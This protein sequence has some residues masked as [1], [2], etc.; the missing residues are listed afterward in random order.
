MD[1]SFSGGGMKGISYLGVLKFFQEHHMT[2][3]I[4]NVSGTSAG[5]LFSLCVVLGYTYEELKTLVDNFN[6]SLIEDFDVNNFFTDYCLD[7]GQ[8]L[9]YF[10]KKILTTKGFASNETFL[11]LYLKTNREL[12]L[13]ATDLDYCRTKIYNYKD[14]PDELVYIA[15]KYSMNIPFLWSK[16]WEKL[17]GCLTI[18]LPIGVFSF[19]N[20]YG[21]SCLSDDNFHPVEDIKD[22]IMKIIKC[23]SIR[24][25]YYEKEYYRSSG[26]KIIDIKLNQIDSLDFDMNRENKQ[27]MI[28][29]GYNATTRYFTV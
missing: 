4:R 20:T 25:D 5:A 11:S 12:Y 27:K 17:D 9:V 16:K 26:Y 6:Y 10:L 22:Y 28:T 29:E 2:H 7:T 18:N 15:C 21:F 23:S 1:L 24:A 3:C 14:T 8:K 13:C 19:E